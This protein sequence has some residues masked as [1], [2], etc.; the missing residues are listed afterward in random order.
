MTRDIN[1][2]IN[3]VLTAGWDGPWVQTGH[4]Q[5]RAG[6]LGPPPA[7]ADLSR[8]EHYGL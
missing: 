6:L 3:E 8:K 4:T 2:S 7:L 1:L 5:H